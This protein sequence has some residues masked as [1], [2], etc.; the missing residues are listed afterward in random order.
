MRLIR[1]I[2]SD[3]PEKKYVAIFDT[4]KT[5]FGSAGMT[6]YTLDSPDTREDRKRRY[7]ARHKA[8]E[9]WKDPTSAGALSRYILW[10]KPTIYASILDYKRR[11]KL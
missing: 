2:K 5:Y 11:F 1:I 4:K 6:D 8:R 10:N 3:R 9:N 7:I